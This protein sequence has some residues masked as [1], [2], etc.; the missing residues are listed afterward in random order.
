M[1]IAPKYESRDLREI[2]AQGFP[3]KGALVLCDLWRKKRKNFQKKIEIYYFFKKATK[4]AEKCFKMIFVEK[5]FYSRK[6]FHL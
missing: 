5:K 1:N 2:F 6:F 3:L 4:C